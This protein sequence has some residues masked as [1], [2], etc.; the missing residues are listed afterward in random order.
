MPS[1]AYGANIGGEPH[2]AA[3]LA[4]DLAVKVVHYSLL[5]HQS[6]EFLTAPGI[7]VD[8]LADIGNTG[9]EFLG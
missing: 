1:F 5:F 4:A 6:H 2:V 9:D 3:V 8:L 7:G